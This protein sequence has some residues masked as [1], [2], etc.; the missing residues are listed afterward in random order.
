M[1]QPPKAGKS[2]QTMLWKQ[3]LGT[4]L[5]PQTQAA[6]HPEAPSYQTLS[7]SRHIQSPCLAGQ[8]QCR[9]GCHCMS[10]P[11]LHSS[12]TTGVPSQQGD[13]APRV[14]R[15]PEVATLPS[16]PHRRGVMEN[17]NGAN[18]VTQQTTSQHLSEQMCQVKF[19]A[20]K[21]YNDGHAG[22]NLNCTETLM[23]CENWS[24]PIRNDNFGL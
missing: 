19:S 22:N 4:E 16:H 1:L 11:L 15:W 21:C 17:T 23:T 7:S 3:T 13:R 24:L 9:V 10:P 6:V 5:L 2:S 14:F 18:A 20:D 12:D 8:R